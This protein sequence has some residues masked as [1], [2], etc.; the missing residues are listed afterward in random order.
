ML[1]FA[2]VESVVTLICVLFLSGIVMGNLAF[3]AGLGI[4]RW[5]LLGLLIGP[6]A[7]PLFNTHKHYAWRR[8]VGK[9]SGSLKC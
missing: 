1:A 3:R 5:T 4:K 9:S 8:S 7:Y 6:V 2:N